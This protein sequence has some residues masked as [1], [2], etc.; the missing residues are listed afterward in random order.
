M[1]RSLPSGLW[2]KITKNFS[3]PEISFFNEL[4]HDSNRL[5]WIIDFLA[6]LGVTRERIDA[7]YAAQRD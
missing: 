1:R 6:P 2:E 3:D 5:D 4:L 7:E